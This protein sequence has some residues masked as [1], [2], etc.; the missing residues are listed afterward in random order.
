MAE[1]KRNLQTKNEALIKEL[2]S[3]KK[4]GLTA[5][6]KASLDSRIET[7]QNELLSKEEVAKKEQSRL[8]KQHEAALQGVAQERDS[9]KN[10]YTSST[11]ERAII[12]EA[13]K[14]QAINPNQLVAILRNTTSMIEETDADGNG[15]GN[16]S[17]KV[18]FDT[19]KDGKA[20]ALEL[21]VIDAV[22]HMKDSEEYFNL[23]KGEGAPGIGATGG[24]KGKN[25][26]IK[27]LAKDPVAYRKARAEGKI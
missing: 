7:L 12:D 25:L 11:I 6:Q 5:E 3:L 26:D 19:V 10:R 23:F 8:Q 21:S 2:E 1:N 15:T 9:W 27:I 17:P 16:F 20:L 4:S 13:L 18:K 14:N 24:A 22:K